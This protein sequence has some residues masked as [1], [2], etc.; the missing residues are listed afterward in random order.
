M[1]LRRSCVESFVCLVYAME[2]GGDAWG[3]KTRGRERIFGWF[4]G[5]FF[6]FIVFESEIHFRTVWDEGFG[7]LGFQIPLVVFF[8]PLQILVCK[9]YFPCVFFG[10]SP[11][12]VRIIL[13]MPFEF[14]YFVYSLY[15][16]ANTV[17]LWHNTESDFEMLS[18]WYQIMHI[19]TLTL[20][21]Q[22]ICFQRMR[23]HSFVWFFALCKW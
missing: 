23:N 15:F 10:I 16:P 21:L 8:F 3:G 12:T 22:N 18:D 6:V 14:S 5:F 11:F 19:I 17:Y 1:L 2:N 13:L 7:F 9:I 20:N 4:C